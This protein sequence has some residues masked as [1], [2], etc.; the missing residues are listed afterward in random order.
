M[1]VYT[2]EPTPPSQGALNLLAGIA[3]LAEALDQ[4]NALGRYQEFV[5]LF[6]RAF[7]RKAGVLDSRSSS[8]HCSPTHN[9]LTVHRAGDPR[10]GGS[11]AHADHRPTFL[12][13]GDVRPWINRIEEAALDVLLDKADWRAPSGSA[14]PVAPRYGVDGFE[15]GMFV[16]Q[17]AAA[18]V[19]VQ[20]LDG[21]RSY[22]LLLAGPLESAIRTGVWVHGSDMR[23]GVAK[24]RSRGR[25]ARPDFV[26][27]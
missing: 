15:S 23:R 19:S 9:A 4:G 7:S 3:L 26:R 21:F 17:N 8:S 22:P 27:H 12:L 20:V 18:S 5:R 13:E 10:V 11:A 2:A 14:Q 25:E 24:G 1:L 16:S 6:E